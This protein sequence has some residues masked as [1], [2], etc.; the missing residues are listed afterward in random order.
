MGDPTRP[1]AR[2]VGRPPP[3]HLLPMRISLR[4]SIFFGIRSRSKRK[5]IPHECGHGVPTAARAASS[6]PGVCTQT[7]DTLFPRAQIRGEGMTGPA[8][9]GRGAGSDKVRGRRITRKRMLDFS[10]LAAVPI[11]RSDC[12]CELALPWPSHR[13]TAPSQ[14]VPVWDVRR[15]RSTTGESGHVG[16][17]VYVQGLLGSL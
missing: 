17:G 2:S 13:T 1:S 10:P 7:K 15:V 6:P 3:Q 5:H 8:M 4:S 16:V 11:G 9:Y 14:L 12:A